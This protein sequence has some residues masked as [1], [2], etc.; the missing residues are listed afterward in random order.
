MGEPYFGR[1]R[2]RWLRIARNI[3]STMYLMLTFC[4]GTEKLAN[5]RDIEFSTCLQPAFRQPD[6]RLVGEVVGPGTRFALPLVHGVF[7]GW[8]VGLGVCAA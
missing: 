8:G 2:Q 5:A 7:V 4:A 6:R 1:A 3:S